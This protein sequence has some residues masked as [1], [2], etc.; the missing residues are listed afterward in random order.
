MTTD[1]LLPVTLFWFVAALYFGGIEME[2][3]GGTG[4]RQLVGLVLSY[5]LF[6]VIWRVLYTMLG[7][8]TAKGYIVATI[9]SLALL[10]IDMLVGFR[11]MGGK[12]HRAPSH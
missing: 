10:P 2:V 7:A 12:L 9:V 11:V 6:V 8:D 3:V 4:F 1:W 5:V